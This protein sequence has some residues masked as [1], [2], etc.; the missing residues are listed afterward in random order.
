[1]SKTTNKFAPA[2][3]HQR[4]GS[5]M[6]ARPR[7]PSVSCS[8]AEQAVGVG[9]YLHRNLGGVR[10]R[11]LRHR[12]LCPPDRGLARP[13]DGACRLR[14]GCDRAGATRAPRVL[15]EEAGEALGRLIV[16]ADSDTGGARRVAEFLLSWWDGA[17]GKWPL[18]NISNVDPE[19]GEDMLIIL[20]SLAQNNVTYAHAW[21]RGT[22]IARLFDRWGWTGRRG[23]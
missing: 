22:D 9:L 3:D 2:D 5:T 19:V 23:A 10:L 18:I 1:M 11:C 16:A 7:K 13:Q 14:A 21:D 8:G 15:F 12:Y 6:S 4:Q 20:A 17:E